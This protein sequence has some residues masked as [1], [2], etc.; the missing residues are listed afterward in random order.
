MIIPKRERLTHSLDIWNPVADPEAPGDRGKL[1]RD[2][3]RGVEPRSFE[4]GKTAL[5][6]LSELEALIT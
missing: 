5:L 2:V 6:M 1:V 4:W 3:G